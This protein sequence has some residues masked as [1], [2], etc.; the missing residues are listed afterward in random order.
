MET[1][2]PPI[3]SDPELANLTFAPVDFETEDL[4]QRLMAAGFDPHRQTFFSW[5]GVVTYLT[6]AAVWN[7]LAFIAN[8]PR[9]THVV[10]DYGDPPD[11]RTPESRAHYE[12]RAHY[13]RAL[14]EAWL[15]S[16][17]KDHLRARLVSLGFDEVEDLGPR[18]IATRY[19]SQML[20][21][22]PDKGLHVL[23]AA[24]GAA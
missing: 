18:E 1:Q 12:R 3:C 6:E 8:L 19:F 15:C 22:L 24:T 7:T 2:A 9:G 23:H 20:S 17:R 13:V 21:V 5:L 11:T 10:F 14:G 16:F 4:A